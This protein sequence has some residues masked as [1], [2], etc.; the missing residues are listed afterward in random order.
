MVLFGALSP[1]CYRAGVDR[2]ALREIKLLQEL[3]HPNIIGVSTVRACVVCACMC[4][5]WVYIDV[6]VGVTHFMYG[7]RV[8]YADFVF[9]VC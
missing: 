2:T 3:S 1:L 7:V 5:V 6:E 8:L 4:S 9:A